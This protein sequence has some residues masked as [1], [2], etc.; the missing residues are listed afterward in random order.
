MLSDQSAGRSQDRVV[1]GGSALGSCVNHPAWLSSDLPRG[2]LSLTDGITV[3]PRHLRFP[4][5]GRIWTAYLT[6][7]IFSDSWV[8]PDDL[9]LQMEYIYVVRYAL[10]GV[11]KAELEF[12]KLNT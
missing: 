5:A 2:V 4:K 1:R 3:E 12:L 10:F 7:S 9:G 8:M 6:S 11:Q